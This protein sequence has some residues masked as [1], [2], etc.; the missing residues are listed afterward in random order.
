MKSVTTLLWTIAPAVLM[1]GCAAPE[2]APS[3]PEPATK[4]VD[5]VARGLKFE[6]PSEIPSGWTT[7]RFKNESTM[8]HFALVE[9]LPEGIGIKEQQEQVA[10]IFQEGM[11]LL[12]AGEADAAMKKF[13]EIPE[14][15]GRV[16]TLGGPGLVGPGG[17]A[18]TTVYLEP[19]THL[20]ECYVKTNGIFHSYNPSPDAYGMVHEF[21]VTD[22][23][24]G[25]EEPVAS[26]RI[27]ISGERGI[28]VDGELVAGTQTVA[29]HF[30]DQ[31]PHENFV[32]HDA[33]LVRLREDTDLEAL[34]K[35][36]DWTQAAGLQTPAPAEFLGGAN[37]LSAGAMS[38]VTVDLEPGR[39]AWI[40]EVPDPAGKN[41]LKTFTV[42]SVGP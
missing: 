8:T 32:G 35:W 2:K 24:S 25:A 12:S 19:G 5:V 41:M 26:A 39:Y 4:V 10:P 21:T 42:P 13:G 6:A 31:K 38:Y 11:D 16:V 22:R 34:A 18:E 28:E 14:W 1:I 20:L 29:V 27:T 9:R 36:M 3:P 33:H 30:E 23:P 15:F 37:E 40:A 17:T 7:F